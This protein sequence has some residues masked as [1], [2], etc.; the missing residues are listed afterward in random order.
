MSTADENANLENILN[1]PFSR[2]MRYGFSEYAKYVIEDR[3]LPDAR[4][5]LKPVHRR[6]LYAMKEL[7]L[8]PRSSFK[9]CA[10]IVGETTGRFHPHAGGVYES[11]VRLGQYWSLRYPLIKPQG[12]FG[13]I[14]GIPPAAMRYTEAR[15]T[16]LSN[17][18]MT[19]EFSDTFSNKIVNFIPNFD[20]EE[21]EPTVLPVNVPN[22]LLNGSYGIA[23]GISS[24]IPPHN[25]NELLDACIAI[26][27]DNNIGLDQ[28]MTHIKGPDFPTGG[29]ILGQK[30]LKD[31]YSKGKGSI[32][33]RS[34]YHLENKETHKVKDSMIVFSEIPYLQSKENLVE[35]IANLILNEKIRGI[36]DVRDLSEGPDAIRIEVV[37]EDQ[38]ANEESVK[39]ILAQLFKFSSLET[40]FHCRMNAFVYGQPYRLSLKQAL[41]VFLDF[42]EKTIRNISKE[43]LE[44]VIYRLHILEGLI[45]AAEKID[46][47]IETI[48]SSE[49]RS[50]ANQ[51]LQKDYSLSEE[52]SQAVLR[53]TLGQ[54]AKADIMKYKQEQ[55]EKIEEKNELENIINNRPVLMNKM[56]DEFISIK[57]KNG[58]ERRSSILEHDEFIDTTDRPK[59]HPRQ[60]LITSTTSGYV[61][62]IDYS[63]FRTQ[64][65]GGRGVVGIPLTDEGVY[66]M[67]IVMNL[68]D[69]LLITNKG[70]IHQI[71]AY[72]ITEVK[73]RT[74]KG[75]K[76]IRY[77]P[78]DGDVVKVVNV[79]HEEYTD[80]RF[81]ITVTKQGQIKRSIL[82]SYENVRKT[83]II[84]LT[85]KDDDDV[86]DA[87][88]TGGNS[89][90]FLA[91]K[92]GQA[93]LFE[94]DQIRVMGRTAQGV[95]GI[96][97]RN[98]DEVV[99]AFTIQN[100]NLTEV[101]ILT[102]TQNGYG[103]R[104]PLN[105][106]R[107]TNRGVQGVK[108]MK[109]TSKNGPVVTSMPV[110]TNAG[111]QKISLVN[112]EG[113]L[114]KVQIEDIRN[115]GRST[116]GVK[117][118]RILKDQKLLMA[119]SITE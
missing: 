116:Q 7:G 105:E 14:D 63:K 97:V 47:I 30:G 77:L 39:T 38:Y 81:L 113:I 95:R 59:L 104:T 93:V 21:L 43:Q 20:E 1:T 9:K 119:S 74:A 4:D 68:D 96:K 8:G 44:K 111:K 100:K 112:S 12:N 107:V 28:L 6:I 19:T 61:R 70:K 51:S 48:K 60:L 90:I 67:N 55:I 41:S 72:E 92:N 106:Y 26:I 117:V 99:S 66:D 40:S 35:S 86:I 76:L 33:I 102:I 101:S 22:L 65:R 87:F 27:D 24:N 13:S 56:R 36:K 91:T 53:M 16:N 5:G 2:E 84:C 108:N 62:A 64:S 32:K 17:D 25:L 45:L 83:G 89:H 71:P 88:I 80:D 54:L 37:I 52:Q 15:L 103:K 31:I 73:S 79:N 3:A 18:F 118:M 11:L 23:V 82:S 115:M 58:D 50:E 49:N 78:I 42:R 46:D 85:L 69:L 57:E 110:P 109:I 29:L 94:E 98:N 10:R 75:N 34:R 114:I